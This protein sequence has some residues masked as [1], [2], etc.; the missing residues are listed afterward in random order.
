MTFFFFCR[1]T[2]LTSVLNLRK[3]IEDGCD[4]DLR[5]IFSELT[6]VG[7]VDRV[8]SLI[9]YD[10]KMFLISTKT[11]CEE[12]CYQM[13]LYN[14]G[15]LTGMFFT[16]PLPL[17]ELA[18]LALQNPESGWTEEDGPMHELVDRI[19]E[20]L[21]SK[22][23][24]MKEYFSLCITE[25]A[26]LESIPVVINDYIPSMA[27]LPMYILRLAT[28]VDWDEEQECFRTFCRETAIYYAKIALGKPEQEYK[29]EIEH[30]ICPALKQYFLPPKLFA[31]NG[32]VLQVAN[33]PD[34]YRVFERC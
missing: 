34:L 5:N 27:F 1:D 8:Q 20:I 2:K 33:L 10:T 26:M 21:I 23:P 7:V 12:L 9:Q 29:W 18:L 19:V 25:D 30:A 31:K 15:N 4:C 28:E 13:L 17:S 6:F 16:N 11:L 32:S 22:A 3:A 14:F 24:I